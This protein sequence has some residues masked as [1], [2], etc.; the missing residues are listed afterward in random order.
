[1]ISHFKG[2]N[3]MTKRYLQKSWCERLGVSS[4]SAQKKEI[5]RLKNV[6]AS[7]E[8]LIKTLYEALN[9]NNENP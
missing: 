5:E 4:S 7:K 6:V 9:R 1:M 2:G 3:T 8:R